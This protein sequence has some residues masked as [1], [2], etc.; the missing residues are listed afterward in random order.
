M[1]IRRK[2][3]NGAELLLRTG[4]RKSVEVREERYKFDN[5]L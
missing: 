1:K 3:A 2:R 5:T 4:N